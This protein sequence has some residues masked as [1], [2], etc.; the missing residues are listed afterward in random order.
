MPIQI[1][2]RDSLARTIQVQCLHCD[3]G[4]DLFLKHVE[5]LEDGIRSTVICPRCRRRFDVP[6][7][8]LVI[9]G[10]LQLARLGGARYTVTFAPSTGPS[11]GMSALLESDD[12]LSAF[13]NALA[14]PVD[15][16][17]QALADL[18]TSTTAVQTM[19]LSLHH[20]KR[21]QLIA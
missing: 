5:R 14:A 9:D 17:A 4:I 12:A 21:A 15:C 8:E 16:Q 19:S 11:N 2:K 7:E 20:L 3:Q 1:L 18:Q 10:R 13:L 6:P